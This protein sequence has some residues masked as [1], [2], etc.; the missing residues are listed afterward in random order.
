MTRSFL[1]CMIIWLLKDA[2]VGDEASHVN[3]MCAHI[4]RPSVVSSR[5]NPSD[6]GRS[7]DGNYCAM[8]FTYVKRRVA[9]T[10]SI[11]R[12]FWDDLFYFRVKI[13]VV[14]VH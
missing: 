5:V 10:R 14:A 13:C 2:G 3:T 1:G 8:Y 12:Q 6:T 4:S 9:D 7:G 11:S